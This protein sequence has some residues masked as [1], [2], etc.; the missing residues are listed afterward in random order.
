MLFSQKILLLGSQTVYSVL[1]IYSTGRIVTENILI[2][3]VFLCITNM[4]DRL[5]IIEADC[6]FKII[7]Q[8]LE[9]LS[10]C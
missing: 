3:N 8:K 2:P 7:L 4:F 5:I 1:L 9:Y 10:F 6:R